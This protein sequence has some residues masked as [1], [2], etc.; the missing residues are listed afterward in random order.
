[1]VKGMVDSDGCW[2]GVVGKGGGGV[3]EIGCGVGGGD[4]LGI[5]AEGSHRQQA[6]NSYDKRHVWFVI[7]SHLFPLRPGLPV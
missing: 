4:G 6:D 2:C 1:M 5:G 7:F 3:R